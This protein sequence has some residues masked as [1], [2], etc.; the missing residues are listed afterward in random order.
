MCVNVYICIC[1]YKEYVYIH[2]VFILSF[3]IKYRNFGNTT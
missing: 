1:V 3:F 2:I